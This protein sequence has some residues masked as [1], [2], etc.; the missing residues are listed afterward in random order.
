MSREQEVNELVIKLSPLLMLRKA[1][2]NKIL[3]MIHQHPLRKN[4]YESDSST[5]NDFMKKKR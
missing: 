5:L 1:K 2:N 3:I 4:E